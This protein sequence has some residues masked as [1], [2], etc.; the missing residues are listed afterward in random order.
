M[1]SRSPGSCSAL[2]R[3]PLPAPPPL[4]QPVATCLPY[5]SK[6]PVAF[7]EVPGSQ[8]CFV[9]ECEEKYLEKD[10]SIKKITDQGIAFSNQCNSVMQERRLSMGAAL[11]RCSSALREPGWDIITSQKQSTGRRTWMPFTV[12]VGSMKTAE[13]RFASPSKKPLA[14]SAS[15]FAVLSSTHDASACCTACADETLC[16]QHYTAAVILP[17]VA[18]AALVVCAFRVW[19]VR[20][21][22]QDNNIHHQQLRHVEAP[23]NV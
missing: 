9:R 10:S 18:R 17:H 13:S 23:E 7:R 5:A 22:R 15:R 14:T 12:M 11:Q 3:H 21:W 19:T 1:Q 8:S 2:R 16:Q 4:F 20:A 6:P